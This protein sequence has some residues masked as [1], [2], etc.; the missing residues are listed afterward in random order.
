MLE[1]LDA[2]LAA[3]EDKQKFFTRIARLYG[4]DSP[5]YLKVKKAYDDAKLAFRGRYRD[6]L[7]EGHHKRYFE[8]LRFVAIIVIDYFGVQDVDI[9]CAALLHDIVEDIHAWSVARVEREFGPTVAYYVQC[10]TKLPVEMFS[11]KDVR[12]QE[13]H[14]QVELAPYAVKLIKLADVLHNT[15]TLG[16]CSLE[17]QHRKAKEITEAY[18]PLAR[19][20]DIA[21]HEL[22]EAVARIVSSWS[23]YPQLRNVKEVEA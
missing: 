7:Y 23:E 6:E 12:N 5:R 3:T 16:Y 10:V 4:V 15:L 1:R 21:A 11:S 2:I 8:H 18:V 22:D 14:R 19:K 13:Y 9:I 17:K 20:Y